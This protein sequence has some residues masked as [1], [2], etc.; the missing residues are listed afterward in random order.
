MAQENNN[1][2]KKSLQY[3]II[4]YLCLGKGKRMIETLYRTHDYL[5]RNKPKTLL[6]GLF[7]ELDETQQLIGIEGSRGIGKT[8]FLL[9]WAKQHYGVANRVC[10]Y[11]NLNQ[12]LFTTTSLTEFASDFV[13]RGGK[14]LLLDQI[15][16]YPGWQ[17]ELKECS[18]KF[19]ELQ[20]IYT[21][22]VSDP[23]NSE[24]IK[25]SANYFLP[26]L[27]LREFLMLESGIELPTI[28]WADLPTKHVEFAHYIM[29][30]VNPLTR[31]SDYLHHGYY[32]F[33]REERNYSE[34]LLK[35]VNMTLEV[36]LMYIRNIDQRMLPKLRKLLYLVALNASAPLN[37][38][39][40]SKEL[41]LSRTTVVNYLLAMA[42]AHLIRLVPRR[43]SIGKSSPKTPSMVY[44]ENSNLYRLMHPSMSD[45]NIVHRTFFQCN[46]GLQHHIEH[47]Q[48]AAE[49]FIVDDEFCFGM[50]RMPRVKDAYR[51]FRIEANSTIGKGESLPLWLFG[52]LY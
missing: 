15:F 19:P 1:V 25:G 17:G 14:T 48:H 10:L 39:R 31:I 34:N 11:V 47:P 49:T 40:L 20:I 7:H 23:S 42:D 36:D 32:P 38:S 9:D 45:E 28:S 44:M 3:R 52:F 46:V 27:S 4:Y 13:S 26:G 50:D 29:E 37:V 33:Y 2:A 6:R 5:L 30:Q 12:F 51:Q 24:P 16:K 18:R 43:S 21:T 35:N 41:E 22:S 8:I